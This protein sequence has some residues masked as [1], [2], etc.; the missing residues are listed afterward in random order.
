MKAHVITG[1]I[2]GGPYEDPNV[3]LTDV[4]PPGQGIVTQNPAQ[5]GQVVPQPPKRSNTF[6]GENLQKWVQTG[7]AL[8]KANNGNSILAGFSFKQLAAAMGVGASI[9]AVAGT[10][11]LPGIFTGPGAVLGAI[12]GAITYVATF[13]VSLFNRPPAEW[14]NAAPGV[15]VWFTNFGPQDYLD[16]VRNTSPGMLGSLEDCIKG[17]APFWLERHGKVLVPV[18]GASFYSGIPDIMYCGAPG[19]TIFNH[20]RAM[21]ES[22]GIDYRKTWLEALPA[23]TSS[24]ISSYIGPDENGNDEISQGLGGVWQKNWKI[25]VPPPTGGSADN[26]DETKEPDTIFGKNSMGMLVILAAGVY[27]SQKKLN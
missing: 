10:V 15:H 12:I 5:V 22:V 8:E 16:W 14:A 3:A 24:S 6:S 11:T 4:V 27:L 20:T 9:G 26:E 7:A 21:Y 23:G 13:V 18:P 17:V 2:T 19:S 25:L 1:T